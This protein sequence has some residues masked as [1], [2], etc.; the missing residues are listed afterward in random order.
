MRCGEISVATSRKRDPLKIMIPSKISN[1]LLPCIT[2]MQKTPLCSTTSV[3]STNAVNDRVLPSEQCASQNP[4]Q[5]VQ[6]ASIITHGARLTGE[7]VHAENYVKH[8]AVSVKLVQYDTSTI[9]LYVRPKRKHMNAT[10]YKMPP[11][12]PSISMV[13]LCVR[14][15]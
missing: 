2:W 6:P 9:R 8:T 12:A 11:G 10:R 3:V 7:V 4:G 14:V 1:A 13:C 15:L 5:N